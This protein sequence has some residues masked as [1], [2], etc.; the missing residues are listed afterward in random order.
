MR[1]DYVPYLRNRLLQPLLSNNKDGCE[2]TIR[3]LDE[4]GLS[5]EDFTES[6]REMQFILEKAT[7]PAEATLKG[8]WTYGSL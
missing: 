2:E 7:N 3:L 4:Y 5:K 8:K 1:L 6:M